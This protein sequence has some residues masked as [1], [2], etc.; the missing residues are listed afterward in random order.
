[1]TGVGWNESKCKF[2]KKMW[3]RIKLGAFSKKLV[4]KRGV[5]KRKTG[6][7][8]NHIEKYSSGKAFYRSQREEE[9]IE[10]QLKM[11]EEKKPSTEKQKDLTEKG[12]ITVFGFFDSVV[13]MTVDTA[14]FVVEV[15][16]TVVSQTLKLGGTVVSESVKEMNDEIVKEFLPNIV[17]LKLP[18]EVKDSVKQAS[19]IVKYGSQLT[20][21]TIHSVT[22]VGKMTGGIVGSTLKTLVP[23]SENSVTLALN[24]LDLFSL[25]GVS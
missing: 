16:S 18:E 4:L 11:E 9:I 23:E 24:F 8:V 1:M 14:S 17:D 7:C 3:K 12:G 6:Y 10:T 25:K 22:Y 21:D 5:L 15:S 20:K 19:E 2:K 13:A